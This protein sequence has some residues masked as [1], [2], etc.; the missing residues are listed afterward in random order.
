MVNTLPSKTKNETSFGEIY[1]TIH[2]YIVS[3]GDNFD[4]FRLQHASWSGAGC[5]NRGPWD[6][7]RLGFPVKN[8]AWICLEHF[9]E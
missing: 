7:K 1:E 5:E 9:K 8:Q 6:G 2:R 4:Y 3:P